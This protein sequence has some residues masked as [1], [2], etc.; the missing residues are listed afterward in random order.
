LSS[1]ALLYSMIS[2]MVF[3]WSGN[4]IVGKIALREIPPLLLAGLRI[5]LAGGMMVPV[6]WWEHRCKKESWDRGDVPLLI[7]LG[8]FGVALN[9]V[10]F[11]LGLNRTSVA[12]ASII[13]GL[14]PVIVLVLASA[15]GQERITSPKLT[16]MCI[17]L[18]GVA[19]LKL[20]E[21]RPPGGGGPTWAGDGF[22]LLAVTTFALFT[23]YGKGATL[24]HS[25]ITVNAFAYIGA[26]LFLAP[27][28]LWQSGHFGF[29]KVSLAGWTSVLYMAAFPSVLCYLIY[30]YALTHM[31]PSRVSAF[32]YLQPPLVTLMGIAFLGEHISTA[33]VVSGLVIFT[34]VWLAE[35]G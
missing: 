31:A 22:I 9:Q 28:T 14:T 29:A 35:R 26:A 16:G 2:V 24:R 13:I 3:F 19:L 23:V 12:H 25:S 1:H 33:L 11:V 27:I 32:N 17:A 5:S 21:K 18:T 20:F 6:Y 8:V 7:G 10:F 15:R 30:Y 34:G 4:Y